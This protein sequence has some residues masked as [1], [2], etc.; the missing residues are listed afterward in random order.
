MKARSLIVKGRPEKLAK[1][2]RRKD[3]GIQ[4]MIRKKE[5]KEKVNRTWE[6]YV[7]LHNKSLQQARSKYQ[8]R[9]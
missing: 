5:I 8:A 9:Y 6:F 2:V 3:K 7:Y 4:I 1:N